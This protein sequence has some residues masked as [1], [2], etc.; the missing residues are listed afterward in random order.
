[1]ASV[2]AAGTAA[3]M[4]LTAGWASAQSG[5]VV[6]AP[7]PTFAAFYTARTMTKRDEFEKTKEFAR[8]VDGAFDLSRVYYFA[9][10]N[11]N[12]AK[13]NAN[14]QYDADNERLVA[15]AGHRPD[16]LAAEEGAGAP[17]V[18]ETVTENQ[19][20]YPGKA[21]DG[22][23]V[24]V[25]RTSVR[26]YVLRV[27]NAPSLPADA[28]AGGESKFMVRAQIPSDEARRVAPDL[29]VVVG[30][31]FAGLSRAR[32]EL[33]YGHAPTVEEP[34][35]TETTVACLDCSVVRVL[36]RHKASGKIYRDLT[37]PVDGTGTGA[38]DAQK[39]PK[40]DKPDPAP[41]AVV[42]KAP[43]KPPRR[44]TARRS[45]SSG[46]IRPKSRPSPRSPSK[47]RW[48][49]RSKSTSTPAIRRN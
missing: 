12:T 45:A 2:K 39:P 30:V 14:Y 36:V 23:K 42:K 3:L 25:Q 13:G 33:V 41:V 29:E 5:P 35:N 49:R 16:H 44:A 37:V 20:N 22:R 8:R 47:G 34:W 17:V 7:A 18:I 38:V 24:T 26:E 48:K 31:R 9:V 6:E 27:L 40:T 32:F 21:A 1:M 10:K 4:L 43:E 11:R 15:I 19:G 46:P 28:F